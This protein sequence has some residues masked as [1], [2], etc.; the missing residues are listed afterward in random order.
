[1]APRL[2]TLTPWSQK[3]K[4]ALGVAATLCG[5][6]AYRAGTG[7]AK[8]EW[9]AACAA[10]LL[11]LSWWCGVLSWLGAW[12]TEEADDEPEESD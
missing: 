11:L 3:L 7:R 9:S 6:A 12:L 5:L 2:P 1:M 4:W 8:L 10:L